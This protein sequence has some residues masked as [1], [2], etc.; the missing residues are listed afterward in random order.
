M[1]RYAPP[2]AI[3]GHPA[4]L[5]CDCAQAGGCDEGV[6]HDVILHEGWK[7]ERQGNGAAVR[8]GFFRNVKDFLNAKP[9]KA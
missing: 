7:F 8:C 1:K 3:I 5:A 6:K 2:K 4:V 9:I